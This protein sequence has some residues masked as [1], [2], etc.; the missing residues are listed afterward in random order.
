M[1]R[2]L[3][4]KLSFQVKSKYRLRNNA[5]VHTPKDDW[6]DRIEVEVGDTK[7][8]STFHSQVKIKRW[9]N[10]VNA[11]FRLIDNEPKQ[12]TTEGKKVKLI[13][14]KKE[15]HLYDIAPNQEH[16]EGGYEFEVILKEKPTSNVLQFSI[17]TKG[18][19]FFY[20]ELADQTLALFE[21]ALIST[22]FAMY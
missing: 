4:N 13:G 22:M 19:D 10:E 2:I 9:D 20:L 8:P 6:R 18:L 15:V 17:Q 21:E 14:S 1:A 5:L 7:Q 11:S 16:K 3:L 12:F